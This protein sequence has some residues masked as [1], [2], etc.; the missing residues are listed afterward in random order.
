MIGI[1]DTGGAN[2]SSIQ[3]A[4]KRLG[5]SS[6]V[7]LEIPV[8]K[9]ASHLIL[10]GV[11]HAAFAMDRIRNAGLEEYLQSTQQPLLGICLGLQILFTKSEEGDVEGLNLFS[12]TVEKM[13]PTE[14]FRVPHM[15]WS[16]LQKTKKKSHLLE[17]IAENAYFYFVHSYRV[18]EMAAVVATAIEPVV[19]PAVLESENRVATQ[20][21]PERSGAAGQRLLENFMNMRGPI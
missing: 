8:L 4:L 12:G 5:E 7:S 17:G 16:R 18:P 20:F 21:H 9:K 10:P 2:H 1:V 19:I 11:G 15:G 6:T 3:N 13:K 14:D